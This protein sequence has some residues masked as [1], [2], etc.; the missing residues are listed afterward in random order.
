MQNSNPYTTL[1]NRAFW[2]LGSVVEKTNGALHHSTIYEPSRK[3]SEHDKI[4][5]VGSCF[6]NEITEYIKRVSITGR[7]SELVQLHIVNSSI[8]NVYTTTQFK[9]LLEWALFSNKAPEKFW[10]SPTGWVNP[11]FQDQEYPT[12]EALIFDQTEKL[13][14]LREDLSD[15]TVLI[16][17]LGLTEEWIFDGNSC[18]IAPQVRHQILDSDASNCYF[19]KLS[20]EQMIDD[21]AAIEQLLNQLTSITN[22][23][24]TVSPVPLIATATGRHILPENEISKASLRV[25]ASHFA[26][27]TESHANYFPS[28]EIIKNHR[29]ASSFFKKNMR[30][31]TDDAVDIVM[32]SFFHAHGYEV[33]K[34]DCDQ[35]KQQIPCLETSIEVALDENT[36][37]QPTFFCPPDCFFLGQSHL[38]RM[39]QNLAVQVNQQQIIPM[40]AFWH[41]FGFVFNEGYSDY[42]SLAADFLET[43]AHSSNRLIVDFLFVPHI[44]IQFAIT[45]LTQQFATFEKQAQRKMSDSEQVEVVSTQKEIFESGFRERLQ[46]KFD[47]IRNFRYDLMFV[48]PPFFP[49]VFFDETSFKMTFPPKTP[50]LRNSTIIDYIIDTYVQVA[51]VFI[52]NHRDVIIGKI[53]RSSIFN[54]MNLWS[55]DGVHAS[56][57]YYYELAKSLHRQLTP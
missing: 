5:S 2:K 15:A 29:Y 44:D 39:I 30:N 56:E 13:N 8:G 6:A 34:D 16:F 35:N 57:K 17:T 19:R 45:S 14:T 38:G 28:Y 21:L 12:L 25:L 41:D 26:D 23:I 32:R 33:T 1:P 46:M 52:E 22:I 42:H 47:Y 40:G 31:V 24:Y 43:G 4:V 9:Q 27:D 10:K 3:L 36:E 48:V 53:E 54:Q 20:L 50:Y 37:E 11:Y 51:T 49:S 7:G 55:G 18:L